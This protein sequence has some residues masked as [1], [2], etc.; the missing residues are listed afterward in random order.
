MSGTVLDLIIPDLI[1]GMSDDDYEALLDIQATNSP[2]E[3]GLKFDG[4]DREL[5]TTL[6][7]FRDR[8]AKGAYAPTQADITNAF[9]YF[10]TPLG[11]LDILRQATLPDTSFIREPY[12]GLVDIE[13]L[14]VSLLYSFDR[15][16]VT[17]DITIRDLVKNGEAQ[18]I[19]VGSGHIVID[20]Q[21]F[22]TSLYELMRIDVDNDGIEEMVAYAYGKPVPNGTLRI[23]R[24]IVLGRKSIADRFAEL[25]V[26][27]D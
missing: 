19:D 4:G 17:E 15:P 10:E 20:W 18:I 7:E 8:M 22:R 25:N 3:V 27:N 23:G 24:L 14:P 5:V 12:A 26:A 13:L 2:I 11:V 21:S 1:H 9:N 6:R 16:M